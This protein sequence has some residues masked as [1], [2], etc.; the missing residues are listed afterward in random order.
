MSSRSGG[1]NSLTARVQILNE[2]IE[3]LRKI[4]QE[5]ERTKAEAGEA[6]T[7]VSRF[8]DSVNTVGRGG[9]AD[10]IAQVR[11]SISGTTNL[12]NQANR[13]V[14]V[15][16]SSAG[17]L[18]KQFQT[19]S[20]ATNNFNSTLGSGV[21]ATKQ[22]SDSIGTIGDRL[23]TSIAAYS[24]TA[25]SAFGLYNAYDNLEKVQQ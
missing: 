13:S 4:V 1:D 18:T 8:G 24:A 6:S 22:F 23:Q 3:N 10:A 5:L 12:A 17:N 2:G 16:A 15:L 19:A 7:A 11:A 14:S 21:G 25:V 20:Q 9:S